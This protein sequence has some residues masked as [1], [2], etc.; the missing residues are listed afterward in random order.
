MPKPSRRAFLRTGAA[1]AAGTAVLR[2]ASAFAAPTATVQATPLTQFDYKDIQL[3]D[4]PMLDQF[5]HNHQ[6]FLN[7]NEDSLLKPFRQLA[8]LP[9]PGEDMG[10][11]YSPSS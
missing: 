4:G 1:L 8:G 2:N 7:L 3:L 9:A 10:G 11:W 5:Q 6:L